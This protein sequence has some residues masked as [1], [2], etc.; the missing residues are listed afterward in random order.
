[1][2]FS[3][4]IL[5]AWMVTRLRVSRRPAA[6]PESRTDG[7]GNPHAGTPPPRYHSH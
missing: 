4:S 2:L 3:L 1:M 7:S 6:L 5:I